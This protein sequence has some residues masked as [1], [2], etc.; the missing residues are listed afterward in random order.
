MVPAIKKSIRHPLLL[1]LALIV[2]LIPFFFTFQG[3]SPAGH[4]MFSIFLLAIVLWISEAIP[5]HATAALIIF[6]EILMISDK[7]ILPAIDGFTAPKYADIYSAL[8]SPVLMLFMGGLFLADGVAKFHLDRNMARVLLKPFGGRTSLII[9]GLMGIT[10]TLSMFMSNTATTATMMPV[11][12][13]VLAGLPANDRLRTALVLCIPIAANIGGIGTPVGTPPNAIALA[14][15]S[16]AGYTI[17]FLQWMLMAMPI[18]LA[19]LVVSWILLLK[20]YPSTTRVIKLEIDSTF[21]KSKSAWI[22]YFTFILTVGLWLTESLHGIKSTVVGFVPV[23]V[24]LCTGVFTMKDLQ[25]IQWHVL[26]LIAGGIAL[27]TGVTCSGLDQWLV[28]LV[29]WDSLPDTSI[30]LVL[31]VMA[32]SLSTVVSNAAT[33]NL[34]VPI[35]LSLGLSGAVN[36]SP[37]LAAVFIAIGSSLAMALPVSTPPNAIAYST[38][39]IKTMDMAKVGVLIGIIGVVLFVKVAPLLWNVM[40]VMSY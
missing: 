13:P 34:L 21:N 20:L 1:L 6:L 32:L 18:M 22:F 19:L 40:G 35:G 24:L 30:T 31:C 12:I 8:A 29:S 3:L 39:M 14:A 10:A 7:S 9:L 25:S 23:V 17:S 27:G 28:S 33:A 16:K 37:V 5:L 2:F 4:R 38:G 36:L 26:W 11:A 15:L